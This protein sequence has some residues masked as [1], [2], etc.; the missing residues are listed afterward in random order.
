ML[1]SFGRITW[2]GFSP[3]IDFQAIVLPAQIYV[4]ENNLEILA[5]QMLLLAL[6][7]EAPETIGLQE[8]TELFL[9]IFGNT[10]IRSQ[11]EEYLCRKADDFIKMVTNFN[12]LN[13]CLG[14]LDLSNLKFAERDQLEAIF[15][16]WRQKNPK[17]FEV[18]EMWDHRLRKHLGARYDSRQNVY[19]WD[20]N[21]K[22]HSKANIINSRE[23]S[24]WRENGIAFDIREAN[25]NIANK[26]LASGEIMKR[27][28]QKHYV[29]GYWGDIVNS[30]YI[31]FGIECEEE[32]FF[33][34]TND[35]Y[36]KTSQDITQ[37]NIMAYM[38]EIAYGTKYQL[39]KDKSETENESDQLGKIQEV[40]EDEEDSDQTISASTEES[41]QALFK[42]LQNFKIYFL[43]LNSL[44]V[45][46]KKSK[47][48]K[49]FNIVYFS[50]SMVHLFKPD[51]QPIL[52][53]GSLIVCESAKYILELKKEQHEEF[54]KRVSGMAKT[55]NCK[56]RQNFDGEK[57]NIFAYLYT[58]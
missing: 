32:S 22:L 10:L 12:Y 25:Y 14:F 37:Y 20:Y 23:Y 35:M 28:G 19:D 41:N 16:F 58:P 39:P 56:V 47:Y 29:R 21:M 7:Y 4:V 48:N 38:H 52:A 15:K 27:E 53:H 8:K 49:L 24:N 36:L 31:A 9:E 50:N 33:K 6:I 54:V 43:P 30:P 55:A 57:D 11:T 18:T 5:R 3:A 46:P 26:S 44:P 45:L 34:K 42:G 17:L 13:Q 2:W 40:N 51:I 1:D